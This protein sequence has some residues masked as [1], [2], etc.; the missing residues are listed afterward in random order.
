MPRRMDRDGDLLLRHLRAAA[1][2]VVFPQTLRKALVLDRY[3]GAPDRSG[4]SA[5]GYLARPQAR[6]AA[7][8][9]HLESVLGPERS[10]FAQGAVEPAL[11][12]RS[13]ARRYPPE[14]RLTSPGWNVYILEH[15]S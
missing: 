7:F 11:R 10:Q 2:A 3:I 8:L 9:S 4:F 1:R 5:L 12:R 13:A 15:R 14:A 6:T